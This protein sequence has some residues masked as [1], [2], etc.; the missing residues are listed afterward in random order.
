[1]RIQFSRRPVLRSVSGSGTRNLPH[2]ARAD[3]RINYPGGILA[4]ALL[5]VNHVTAVDVVRASRNPTD[6]NKTL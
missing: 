2:R 5:V 6:L 4:M 3:H 1:V